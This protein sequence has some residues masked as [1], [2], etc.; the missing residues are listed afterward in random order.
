MKKLILLL[1]FVTLISCGDNKE[2]LFYDFMNDKMI[3]AV[4]MSA[5]DLEL[6]VISIEFSKPIIA[7]DS[8]ESY[9][10]SL[11]LLENTLSDI[12]VSD[13]EMN[14]TIK[15]AENNLKKYM[16]QKDRTR[17]TYARYLLNQIIDKSEKLKKSSEEQLEENKTNFKI[18]SSDIESIKSRLE[19]LNTDTEKIISNEYEV[20]LSMF[21]P[22]EK[23]R[24][25]MKMTAYTN[26]DDTKFIS[27]ELK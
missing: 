3:E 15:K 20:T 11:K 19:V 7:K 9:S 2:K 26:S 14:S 17:D 25:T 12:K 16:R 5:E 4:K 18:F 1:F 23:L 27:G 8:I 22:D 24:K 13:K 10:E 21:M 6:E